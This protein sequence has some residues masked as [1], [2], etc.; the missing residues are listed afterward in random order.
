MTMLAGSLRLIIQIA[1]WVSGF[2]GAVWRVPQLSD[3][4]LL[5]AI[6]FFMGLAGQWWVGKRRLFVLVLIIIAFTGARTSQP[7]LYILGRGSD[8]AFVDTSGELSMVQ[9]P[10][11]KFITQQWFD[12]AGRKLKV[13]DAVCTEKLCQFVMQ[14][15]VKVGIAYS[16]EAALQGCE[17]FDLVIS[18]R[19]RP[20]GCKANF[21]STS[22]FTPHRVYMIYKGARKGVC[23][24]SR[25]NQGQ[26]DQ[27]PKWEICSTHVQGWR[28]WH[29]WRNEILAQL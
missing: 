25:S 2:S 6:V 8:V 9:A 20:S 29:K 4:Y 14:G 13:L 28:I 21:I 7:D 10:R 16:N 18:P 15:S 24:K 17:K 22:K 11:N 5:C 3:A 23:D 1:D 27:T 19:R 12:G 26:D